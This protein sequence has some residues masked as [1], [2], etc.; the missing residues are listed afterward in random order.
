MTLVSVGSGKPGCVVASNR[1]SGKVLYCSGL[2]SRL[3]HFRIL[4][5]ILYDLL[6]PTIRRSASNIKISGKEFQAFVYERPFDQRYIHHLLEI[7]LSV[8]KF[9]GQ[10]FS[11]TT[12][13]TVIRRSFHAGLVQRAEHG[14]LFSCLNLTTEL[15]TAIYLRQEALRIQVLVIWTLWLRFFSSLFQ[16]FH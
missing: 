10:G 15:F 11:K 5:P 3:I 6:D 4:D 14:D 2:L 12:K 9:G 7:L 13:S 1:I 8:V 16:S